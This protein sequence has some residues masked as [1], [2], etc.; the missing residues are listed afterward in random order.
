[1]PGM[2][3]NMVNDPALL[4]S[5]ISAT[6]GSPVPGQQQQQQQQPQQQHNQQQQQHQP[7]D[8]QA[9]EGSSLQHLP[10]PPAQQP[11]APPAGRASLAS[12]HPGA[13]GCGTGATPPHH[14][15][16]DW[17]RGSGPAAIWNSFDD[18]AAKGMVDGLVGGEDG[19]VSQHMPMW[20]P[21][22]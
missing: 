18:A 11:P 1:M 20:T 6:G 3:P 22:V 21:N 7:Q 17:A 2:V 19:G 16:P 5:S 10:S 8:M 13:E 4:G 12:G 9:T 14:T 15:R